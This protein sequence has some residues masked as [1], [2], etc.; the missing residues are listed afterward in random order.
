MNGIHENH[1]MINF[2]LWFYGCFWGLPFPVSFH[3]GHHVSDE[4][5]WKWNLEGRDRTESWGQS[6]WH[7]EKRPL[8]Y[9][10]KWLW[11]K[12]QNNWL[13]IQEE[14]K[15]PSQ[16]AHQHQ[17][18]CRKE[19]L[20]TFLCCSVKI[21]GGYFKHEPFP[22]EKRK[23]VLLHSWFLWNNFNKLKTSTS[24]K[25]ECK[26]G[27]LLPCIFLLFHYWALFNEGPKVLHLPT[28]SWGEGWSCHQE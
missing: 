13:Q 24:P 3:C 22:L 18:H 12:R 8:R 14:K 28:V 23:P 1:L 7:L 2:L 5:F 4:N 9:W 26:L 16:I 17:S 6:C 27:L 21:R 10:Q 25:R 15:N 20:V 11:G 19:N